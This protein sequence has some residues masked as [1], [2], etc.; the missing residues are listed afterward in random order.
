MGVDE[1]MKHEQGAGRPRLNVSVSTNETDVLMPAPI[2]M[3]N[4]LV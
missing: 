4:R 2:I 1:Q 3:R